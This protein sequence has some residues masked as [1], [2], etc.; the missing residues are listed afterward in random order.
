M[1][2]HLNLIYIK[3][4]FQFNQYYIYLVK[5]PYFYIS[6]NSNCASWSGVNL[7]RASGVIPWAAAAAIR[8]ADGLAGAAVV[9]GAVV[10]IAAEPFAGVVVTIGDVTAARVTPLN[11]WRTA[12]RV[13]KILKRFVSNN[14]FGATT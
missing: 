5:F 8:A 6:N 12:R 2:S 13:C 9:V 4:A 10:V 1:D 3:N 7:L 14:A 11:A